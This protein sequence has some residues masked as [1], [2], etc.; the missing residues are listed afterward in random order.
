MEAVMY[1][2]SLGVILER[3]SV[4]NYTGNP[5]SIEDIDKI[6]H[7]AMAAPAAIHMLPWRFIVIREKQMLKKLSDGLPFAKMLEQAGT[8]IV[9]CVEPKDAALGKEEFAILDGA[10]ASEN[11]LL[12]AEALELGAVWT[13]IYPNKESMDFVRKELRIPSN[14]IPLNLIP[15]G[16]PTGEDK[17]QNKYDATNIHW[18]EW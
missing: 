11:I 18:E 4:R 5:V 2:D 10:C 8:G 17:T 13:A 1:K 7:A 15:I 3:K 9:V 12:A 16:Y 6:L 14:I